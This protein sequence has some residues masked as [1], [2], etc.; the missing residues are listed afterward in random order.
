MMHLSHIAIDLEGWYGLNHSG[1]LQR[2]FNP[3]REGTEEVLSP[4]QGPDTVT[5]KEELEQDAKTHRLVGHNA[6]MQYLS[7]LAEDTTT[8]YGQKVPK[9]TVL[10]LRQD[11]DTVENPY[12]F[13]SAGLVSPAPRPGVHFIGFAPSGQLF[14]K[15]RREM[16]SVDLQ[17]KY[18]LPDE[19]TGFTKFLVTTH[20]QNYL[21][22][23]REHRSFPLAEF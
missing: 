16:D 4:G 10:F 9:G 19:N 1:R 14:E 8:A 7:R 12:L 11:F 13:D 22:P 3:R 15:M 17:K 6:Q 20:R 21:E 23:S 2:M 18:N 5:F